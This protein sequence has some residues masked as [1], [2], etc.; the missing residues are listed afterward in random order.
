MT[1][2]LAITFDFFQKFP[3]NFSGYF[4]DR[5]QLITKTLVF[6]KMR[7]HW[8]LSYFVRTFIFAVTNVTKISFVIFH[9]FPREICLTLKALAKIC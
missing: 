2:G 8:S 9:G 5:T 3:F 4:F 6:T 1:L 7:D